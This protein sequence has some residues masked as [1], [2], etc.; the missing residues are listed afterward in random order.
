MPP[1]GKEANSQSCPTAKYNLSS[2]QAKKPD[3]RTQEAMDGVHPIALVGSQ[4][5]SIVQL[6]I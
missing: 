5:S 3:Q 1:L 2:Y 6:L 4:I